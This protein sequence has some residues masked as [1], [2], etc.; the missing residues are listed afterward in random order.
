MYLLRGLLATVAATG[1]AACNNLHLPEP[2]GCTSEEGHKAVVNAMT[3]ALESEVGDYYGGDVAKTVSRSKIRAFLKEIDFKILDVR[4]SKEDPNSTKRFC[5]GDL[6]VIYSV[7]TILDAEKANEVL[8]TESLSKRAERFDYKRNANSF[9]MP[10]DFNIQPTDDGTKIYAE[11]ED[12]DNILAFNAE[13]I[14]DA[15]MRRALESRKIEQD[16]EAARAEAE[17]A[18]VQAEQRAASLAESKATMDLSVQAINAVWQ[19][20]DGGVRGQLLPIQRAWIKRKSAECKIEAA[21]ASVDQTEREVARMQCE[22]RMNNE[23][24]QE[25]ISISYQGQY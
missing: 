19:S 14:A 2:V 24:R 16:Q 7:N 21:E 13:I 15:L 23:R 9:T 12:S 22:T 18:R 5:T 20:L 11:I 8:Q 4:T 25:L 1:L 3:E 6:K 17:A 10:I